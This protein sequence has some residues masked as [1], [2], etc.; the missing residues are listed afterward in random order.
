MQFDDAPLPAALPVSVIIVTWNCEATLAACLS[1]LEASR[2]ASPARV[3]CVDNGSADASTTIARAHGAEVVDLGT[4]AGFPRAVNAALPMCRSDYVLLLNPDV[5]LEPDTIA[6]CLAVLERDATIG[7]AGANLRQ[8]DGRADLAAARR[9][10]TLG[11]LAVETVGLTRL[12]RGWDRQY[13]PAWDRTTSRDVPCINGAFA[14]LKTDLFREIGGLDESVFLYLEDQQLCRDVAAR[15]LRV[16]FVADAVAVHAGAA[17]TR[18]ARPDQQA[19]AYLH[20]MDASIEIIRRI[21]GRT[22]ARIAVILWTV[23][24]VVG[25]TGAVIVRDAVLT[26]RYKAALSWLVGQLRRRRPPPPVPE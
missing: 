24:A 12:S 8:A 20:R 19:T 15:A 17:A 9:F 6:T 22:H 26:R 14:L 11:L 1:A 4:N 7:L 23:R 10:R 25:L 3:I 5:Y 2:P 13:I 21:Q 16:R 18:A